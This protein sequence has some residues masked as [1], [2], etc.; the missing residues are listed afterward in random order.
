MSFLYSM[1]QLEILKLWFSFSGVI[2]FFFLAFLSQFQISIKLSNWIIEYPVSEYQN[3]KYPSRWSNWI[4][5]KKKFQ[6]RFKISIRTRSYWRFTY[7]SPVLIR[8]DLQILEFERDY[9]L[10][11]QKGLRI[12]SKK[13]ISIQ[14]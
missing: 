3:F 12:S 8:T 9:E 7:I 10:E 5:S 2:F 4:S 11:E 14:I 13:K 1:V 6:Y